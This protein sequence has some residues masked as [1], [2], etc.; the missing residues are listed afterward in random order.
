MLD[1]RLNK[2]VTP[3]FFSLPTFL[4]TSQA[5]H[6]N[7]TCDQMSA[8]FQYV[9]LSLIKTTTSMKQLLSLLLLLSLFTLNASGQT[10]PTAQGLPY[11]QDFSLVTHSSSTYPAGWQGHTIA[12]APGGV[13]NTTGPTADRTLTASSTAATNSGN[14]HNFDGKL[15]FLNS[16]S[17]DLT[18]TLALNTSGF[19][20]VEVDYDIM[21]IRNPHNGGTNTRINEVSLQ[22]RVGTSGAWTTVSG[23]EYQNN[24]TEQITAVTTPQKLESKTVMLP[25]ACDNQPV[26][27]V[28][29]ASRQVSGGGARPSF[30]LDNINVEGAPI[31]GANII[32]ST[33]SL[34]SFGNIEVSSTSASQTYTV[35]GDDLTG[36]VTIT[37]PAQFQVSTDNVSFSSS[38]VL[39]QSGGN[40]VGEPVTIYARFSPS[41]AGAASGNITHSSPSATTQNVA[42]SG[43]GVNPPVTYTWID[44]DGDF[45]VA[46]NWTPSRTTPAINDILVFNGS[47]FSGLRTVSNLPAT[48]SVAQIRVINNAS[49]I[50]TADAAASTLTIDGGLSGDDFEVALGSSL[51]LD[52]TASDRAITISITTGETGT[53]GGT[54]EVRGAAHRLLAADA[55]SLLVSGTVA[56]LPDFTG[57]LFGTTNLNSVVFQN[58]STYSQGAGSNPFGAGVPNS[59]VVFQTGSLYRFTAASGA[60]SLSGRTY[61]NFEYASSQTLNSTGGNP[62]T[63]NSL[64]VLSGT[65]NLNLTGGITIN[66][67]LSVAG[68]ATLGFNP[69]S[70]NTLTF[71]GTFQDISNAGTLTF[72]SNTNIISNSTLLSLGS[73]ITVPGNFTANGEVGGE[74]L[75]VGGAITNP[76]NI[77]NLGLASFNLPNATP[78][79]SSLLG[80]DIA[81]GDALNDVSVSRSTTPVEIGL[82]IGINRRWVITTTTPSFAARNV[83]FSWPVSA[84]N[85]R[86]PASF[87]VWKS[88][89]NGAT[90]FPI[91]GTFNT[92]GDPITVT[93]SATSFSEFTVSDAD[94]PL[95][96]QLNSFTGISTI[97]GVELAWGVSSE[98]DNAGF[99]V[100][101][102]GQQIAHYS[103]TPELQG[104]GTTSEAKTYRYVDASSNLEVGKSY[105]Y[106]LRSV[107]FDGTIHTISRNAVVQVSQTPNVAFA[108]KL[109]QNYPN[110]FNPS[111]RITF[112]IKD[113][114][115]VSLKVYDLLGREVATLVNERRAAGIYDVNFNAANFGS[116]VYFYTLSSGG[117]SQTKKM[118][119]V[120]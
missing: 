10:N 42:V 70:S 108:Y 95:P 120:K 49:V 71:N 83:T 2:N 20:S 23:Q 107:D 45:Q 11:T 98:Q 118:L 76:D 102:D 35:S 59:V 68:G 8:F 66:G 85:G 64:D 89:D 48:Q 13:Y 60:P 58:G 50:F 78:F 93:V 53:L 105:T 100:F 57:N 18:L 116:G 117:F 88:T 3:L 73:P 75:I 94:N 61:A 113:A 91:P 97:R 56:T 9:I 62:L 47:L 96:V 5:K 32:V 72:N 109:E 41:S 40:V 36:D 17:L 6:R 77:G 16:A 33:S 115:F 30:A 111:T 92:A 22:Y 110:P 34:P 74:V 1:E 55:S 86:N 104:R 29:W 65:F 52:T 51:R 112:S 99:I 106:T 84:N 15:G 46:S 114:G 4:R 44:A 19:Q 69:A 39:T 119:F 24:T 81:A 90:W 7:L 26:V 43:T 31:A 25:A 87:Q 82:N 12:T 21:T 38:V 28:R 103:T 101:R 27:Q 80:I 79:S 37:A 67:N 14:V 63:V 54:F